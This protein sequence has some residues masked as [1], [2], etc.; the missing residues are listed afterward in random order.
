MSA[1]LVTTS[2]LNPDP[3]ATPLNLTQLVQYLATLVHSEIQGDYLSY[4]VQNE[5][6][7]A[8][9][10]DKVWIEVDEQGRPV[11][12]KI[13]WTG[14]GSWRR[15]YN[16]MLGEVRGY[17]GNPGTDFTPTG[18]GRAGQLYDGWHLCNGND[19]APDYSDHFLIGAHMNNAS[20]SGYIDDEWVTWI[21]N[22]TGMHTGGERDF[23]L[24][25]NNIFQAGG[26]I[27]Q[28]TVGKYTIA[29]SLLDVA[30]DIWGTPSLSTPAKNQELNVVT[31]G[32][33]EPE[34]VSIIP[35]FIAMA[36][37]IFLGYQS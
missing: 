19:G 12:I 17:T 24:A 37:I 16:G 28:L 15:V 1:P 9:D 20:H 29:G 14:S 7:G 21:S 3:N 23:T 10:R 31:D 4:L 11:N 6:P 22:T 5:Q 35:P 30:G 36:W 25:A 18:W 27:G 33:V 8:S 32:F 26:T 13:W 34:A 2:F